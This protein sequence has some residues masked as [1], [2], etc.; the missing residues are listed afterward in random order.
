MPLQDVV[1]DFVKPIMVAPVFP[2]PMS[3]F[4]KSLSIEYLIPGVSEFPNNMVAIMEPNQ[5]FIEAFM[6]GLNHEMAREL[7]WRGFP[8]D[9]M[10]SCFRQFWNPRDYIQPEPSDGVELADIAFMDTWT[11][12]L[13]QHEAINSIEPGLVLIFR[14]DL[15]RKFP[16]VIIFAQRAEYYKKKGQKKRRIVQ[17]DD[18]INFKFPIS[19][20]LIEPD[21]NI[22]GFDLT[23]ESAGGDDKDAGWFFVFQERLGEA[24]FGLDD[25]NL[26]IPPPASPSLKSWNE[27]D[28]AHI[29]S[30]TAINIDSLINEP[31]SID[32]NGIIW[33]KDAAHMAYILYQAPVMLAL[34]SS[35]FLPPKSPII[36][37]DILTETKRKQIG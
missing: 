26:L 5:Q 17:S 27:L 20:F 36:H 9:Q 35:A 1:L 24:R 14:G 34:H 19:K 4:L 28:W 8:T 11:K 12:Q 15:F 2:Y 25:Q 21:I 22:V 18:P 31:S 3:D 6:A 32:K 23:V 37:S 10:G 29:N 13:G 7:L 33:G 16:N 30:Q